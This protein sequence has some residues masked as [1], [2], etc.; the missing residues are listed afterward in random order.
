MET[1]N[2]VKILLIGYGYWGKIWYKTIKKSPYKLVGVVD[3]RFSELVQLVDDTAD[4]YGKLEEVDVDFTH[5]IIATPPSTHLAIYEELQDKFKLTSNKILVEKP[6]G[7]SYQETLLMADACHGLVWL[8]DTPYRNLKKIIK[9]E[10]LIGDIVLY[11]S[12]RASMGPRIRTDVSIIEDYLF[13]DIYL[14]LDLTNR[15]R[16]IEDDIEVNYCN[17][18]KSIFNDHDS[19]IKQD[20]VTLGLSDINGGS[21]HT[22][23]EMFSSWI[24]PKKERKI[25]IVGTNGSIIWD[26]DSIFINKDY[27]S[28]YEDPFKLDQHGNVGYQL[29]TFNDPL[30][31]D[32]DKSDKTNLEKLLDDFIGKTIFSGDDELVLKSYK[33]T[34]K[35][36]V[37]NTHKIINKIYGVN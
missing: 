5:V 12:F 32:I 29:N 10:K 1:N 3:A 35:Q 26:N 16:N 31:P 4:S 13:H 14:Y 23:V 37:I 17:L 11:Q 6:V 22:D 8:Y 21:H 34:Q 18:R 27:Y 9:H 36:L 30:S 28:K 7:T 25:V 20:T 15:F 19:L 33:T 24:Y 2:D